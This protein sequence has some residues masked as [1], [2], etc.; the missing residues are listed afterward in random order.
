VVYRWAWGRVRRG[1]ALG[2]N[3]AAIAFFDMGSLQRRVLFLVQ[4]KPPA[5]RRRHKNLTMLLGM[6]RLF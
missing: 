5:G 4:E 2:R 1:R 6:T 3:N